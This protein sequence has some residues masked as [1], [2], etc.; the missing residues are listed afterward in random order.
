VVR[1]WLSV[2]LAVVLASVPAA[3]V[4]RVPNLAEER[5]S[6]F[7]VDEGDGYALYERGDYLAAIA[8]FRKVL[9]TE[10][11]NS[12]AYEGLVW[13]YLALG[14]MERAA[15]AADEW[16]AADSS[17]AAVLAWA[18][19]AIDID[20]QAV[21][22][23]EA[24]REVLPHYATDVAL[25]MSF[26]EALADAGVLEEAE[27]EFS[28]AV[29][30]SP[31][32]DARVGLVE[33]RMA[34]G[35]WDGAT[36][37]LN[38][39]IGESPQDVDLLL[40]RAEVALELGRLP[41]MGIDLHHSLTLSSHHAR[42]RALLGRGIKRAWGLLGTGDPVPA[43][44][45][46]AAVQRDHLTA[47]KGLAWSLIKLRDWGAA[48]AAADGWLARTTRSSK[49]LEEWQV[50]H[51]RIER[52]RHAD[53]G[54][55]RGVRGAAFRRPSERKAP[56]PPA[57]PPSQVGAPPRGE[58]RPLPPVVA[59]P[60]HEPSA[61]FAHRGTLLGLVWVH[62][63]EGRLGE[64]S[65]ILEEMVA[66]DPQD[67]EAAL[68][69][70]KV[71]HWRGRPHAAR[72]HLSQSADLLS[73][74]RPQAARALLELDRDRLGAAHRT[75]VKAR[76]LGPDLA[77]TATAGERLQQALTPRYA[78]AQTVS[79]ETDAEAPSMVRLTTQLGARHHLAPGSL[80]GIDISWTR[81][82][83]LVDRADRFGVGAGLTQE[84]PADLET[85]LRYRI[86]LFPSSRAQHSV[87]LTGSYRP[88][89]VPV[90]LQVGCQHRPWV[91]RSLVYDETLLLRRLVGSN[92]MHTPAI[93]EG[94]FGSEL[95][96]KAST[97]AIPGG[98]AYAEADLGLL[99]DGNSRRA[100]GGGVGVDVLAVEKHGRPHALFVK[101]GFQALSFN[102][103]SA[104]YFSPESW[105]RH[106]LSTAWRWRTKAGFIAAEGGAALQP[107][108]RISYSAGGAVG[109]HLGTDATL[110]VDGSFSRSP[111]YGIAG[112]ALLV[113][114]HP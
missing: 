20:G 44:A 11:T 18:E 48:E 104:E 77:E 101:Y 55:P 14:D 57:S 46:F 110:R 1:W 6:W 39:L 53:K 32:K 21:S 5:L 86:D 74:G 72:R 33:V 59:V 111:S 28:A 91:D 63:R 95:F 36:A 105:Q 92:G 102:E 22:A 41:A 80:L 107:G 90:S 96:L 16:R 47:A 49:E 58:P 94:L 50:M 62:A 99:S 42:G 19:I 9:E 98:F 13:S 108:N 100:F 26:A 2:C 82:A 17:P 24:Y 112:A 79:V 83:D 81:F 93:R 114:L 84:L 52:G 71:D 25:R 68:I 29:A 35:D 61:A 8:S 3:V 51:A 97:G 78:L 64:A 56:P 10:P 60:K 45:F 23:L 7:E 85:D 67:G 38:T 4:V 75:L 30:L 40:K 109:V 65:R 37:A 66:R 54:P 103:P 89:A 70:G 69:L 106:R 12:S 34:R 88:A 27:A 15:R 31:T 73:D 113:E 76:A 87:A 43:A